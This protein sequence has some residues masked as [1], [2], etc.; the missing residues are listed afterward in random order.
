MAVCLPGHDA[1]AGNCRVAGRAGSSRR[2]QP[3]ARFRR[4]AGRCW[5]ARGPTGRRPRDTAWTGRWETGPPRPDGRIWI[6]AARDGDSAG[7]AAEPASALTSRLASCQGLSSVAS[8]PRIIDRKTAN[9]PALEGQPFDDRVVQR[10]ANR[11][12]RFVLSG[13]MHTIREQ[14]D[15]DVVCR[16]DPYR[17]ACE[18]G[19]PKRLGRHS[20]STR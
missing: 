11:A 4:T 3:R 10:G 1:G 8:D 15:V 20:R 7:A 5:W 12:N 2:S 19:V 18:S 16:I 9:R 14:D 13:R 17:R 6:P